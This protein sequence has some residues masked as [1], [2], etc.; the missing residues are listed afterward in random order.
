[1]TATPT[2]LPRHFIPQSFAL[3]TWA[4]VQTYFDDLQ[5]TNLDSLPALET[6][7]L[8]LSELQAVISEDACWRQIKMTCDTTDE[9]LEQ[10]YTFFCTD[11]QPHISAAADALNKKLMACPF[12]QQLDKDK[13]AI[14]LRSVQKDIELFTEKNIPL[15][16]QESVLGQQFGSISSKM[17]VTVNNQE[18]TMQQAMPLLMQS[19]RSLRKETYDKIAA[20]RLQDKDALNKLFDE[21]LALRH[22]IAINAGFTN[23]RDYKF[24][25]L[26]RFDYGVAECEQFH[27]AVKEFILPLCE[28]IYEQK[29]IKLNVDKLHVYDVEAEPEGIAP[30]HPF[31]NGQDLIAKSIAVFDELG[32]FFGDC[33]RTMQSMQHLDLDSR[34]GKAPGGYNCPLAET[35]VPFIFM[36]AAST[37]DDVVT[38]MHEGGHAIHSFVCHDLQLSA[39]KEYP[40]E[41]AELASMSMEL[42]TMEYW[43]QF[44]TDPTHLQRAKAEELE[45][46]LTILPWI[47]TIDKFQHWLYT[48]VGH[49]VQ[50]RQDKWI[51]ILQ[52]FSV[53]TI[54]YSGYEEYRAN[55]WQKQLHLFEVPFYYIEYGI[56]Q[57]GAIGMWMQY[58]QN[59]TATLQKYLDALSLGNTK[60]LK[61]L[62]AT[63]GLEFDFGKDRIKNLSAFV[64]AEVIKLGIL[65]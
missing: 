5:N 38:M 24:K 37:A 21:L 65:N 3:N 61:E 63:A 12:T 2:K 60:G 34:K 18:Y 15:Q 17:T 30:L 19:N 43:H 64:N 11:I 44:Y 23:Y 56:A 42:F 4:D 50:Q 35:G 53:Q 48:N 22:Q 14:Y 62:Y 46:V 25:E 45:R 49:S 52:E 41:I 59:P 6:W 36:N 55:F 20:R 28:T 9:T 7:L 26:G 13:Y 27:E 29:R 58:K 57:L 47:A 40:M 51:E 54:D 31:D 8:Q 10:S 32:S 16:S 1:M 39:F 33:L